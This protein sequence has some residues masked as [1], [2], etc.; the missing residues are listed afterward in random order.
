MGGCARRHQARE[1]TP[2]HF[3]F[4][5]VLAHFLRVSLRLEREILQGGDDAL[6]FD[7]VR[8]IR[9]E[10][11]TQVLQ[12]R[13]EDG[14]PGARGDGEMPVGAGDGEGPLVVEQANVAM[15]ED[16]PILVPQD[17]EQHFV[18]QDRLRGSPVNVK[19]V[20]VGRAWAILGTSCHH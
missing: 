6:Q 8:V 10:R 3:F 14:N 17:G 13:R 11:R 20:C 18:C 4:T 1:A 5:L 12:R 15:F 19:E 9:R 16:F 2:P 7:Q